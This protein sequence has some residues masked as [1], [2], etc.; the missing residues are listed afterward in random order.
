MKN[1]IWVFIL[2]VVLAGAAVQAADKNDSL[3]IHW[4][5]FTVS[6]KEPQGWKGDSANAMFS[7]VNLVFYR[8][9]EN[10]QNAKVLIRVLVTRKTDEN[11]IEDLKHDMEGYRRLYPKIEFADIDVKHPEYKSYAKLFYLKNGV[12]EYVTYVNAGKNHPYLISVSMTSHN[13]K[14][15]NEDMRAYSSIVR[16]LRAM[17]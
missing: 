9:N 14:A 16:S 15:G 8:V 13:K 17:R 4:D 2:C 3:L 5:K 1:S 6:M 11:T 10:V 7:R 12:H